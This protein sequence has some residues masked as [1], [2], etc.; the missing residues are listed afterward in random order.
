MMHLFDRTHVLAIGRPAATVSTSA[1]D[2]DRET[3]R[4]PVVH[5]ARR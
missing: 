2:S 4:I 1:G 5:P 3:R